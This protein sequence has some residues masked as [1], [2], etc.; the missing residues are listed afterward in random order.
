MLQQSNSR[1]EGK[2]MIVNAF[3]L[4][5]N[6]TCR[7]RLGTGLNSISALACSIAT[8]LVIRCKRGHGYVSRCIPGLS[9]NSP[10][11][12]SEILKQRPGQDHA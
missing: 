4:K 7:L 9:N 8:E 12:S 10:A 11:Q 2:P 3:K 5:N 1:L 6:E